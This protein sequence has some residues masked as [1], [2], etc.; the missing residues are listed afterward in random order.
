MMTISMKAG[1]AAALAASTLIV[2]PAIAAEAEGATIAVRY[3]DLDLST[4]EGQRALERRM[5]N[6]A[7]QVCGIDRRTSGNVLP[8]NESLRCYR[9]TVKNFER[10]IAAVA[11]R[12]QRG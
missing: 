1:L 6:A 7:E 2:T 3:S 8:S 10:E 12:Q 9:E 4:Q 5:E 11:E